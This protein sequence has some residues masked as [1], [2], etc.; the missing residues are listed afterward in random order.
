MD[1]SSTEGLSGIEYTESL[2]YSAGILK[3]NVSNTCL[4]YGLHGVK[5]DGSVHKG[6][7]GG[8]IEKEPV[9]VTLQIL[10]QMV[11]LFVVMGN[12]N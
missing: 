8:F 11:H 4:V 7:E 10:I 5:K 3:D 6:I 12:L 1:R 2:L 9:Q